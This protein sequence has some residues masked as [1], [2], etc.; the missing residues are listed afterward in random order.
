VQRRATK[1]VPGL[2]KLNNVDRLCRMDLP[3]MEYRRNRGD[4]IETYKYLGVKYMCDTMSLLPLHEST[5]MM[6][7]GHCIKLRKRESAIAAPGRTFTVSYLSACGTHYLRKLWLR[8]QVN[9]FKG[10]LDYWNA[11]RTWCH[12]NTIGLLA[13]CLHRSEEWMN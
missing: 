10:R 6:T 8:N 11:E 12:L 4:A 9:C 3:S 2:C 7:R 5:G 13:A 1:M